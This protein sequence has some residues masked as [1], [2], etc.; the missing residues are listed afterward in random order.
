MKLSHLYEGFPEDLATSAGVGRGVTAGE[1]ENDPN[2]V[3]KTGDKNRGGRGVPGM[4]RRSGNQNTA[5]SPRHQQF[6]AGPKSGDSLE[7]GTESDREE[8]GI[9][10]PGQTIKTERP[11]P[12]RAG[13]PPRS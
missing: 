9:L 11:V 2:R 12:N 5:M 1:K 8:D 10:N 6:F 4:P 13:R 7:D 3:E